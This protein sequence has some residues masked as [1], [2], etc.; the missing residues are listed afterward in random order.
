[1]RKL[2]LPFAL[3]GAM[4]AAVVV[5]GQS[6]AADNLPDLVIRSVELEASG[7]CGTVLPLVTGKLVI[8]NVS[9]VRAPLVVGAPLLEVRDFDNGRFFDKDYR[10]LESLAPGETATAQARV[11]A[12]RDKTGMVGVRRYVA[13]ADPNNKIKE[14]NEANNSYLV[15]VRVNCP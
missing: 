8:K 6:D 13:I 9:D 2:S 12:M 14:S 1:M 11:G 15:Y 10:P 3:I 4:L 7:N 5:P